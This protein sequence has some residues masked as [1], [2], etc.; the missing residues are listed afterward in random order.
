M[1][2]PLVKTADQANDRERLDYP[3]LAAGVRSQVRIYSSLEELPTSVLNLFE[4]AGCQSIF[5]TLPWF[6]NF[7]KTA[8]APEDRVRIYSFAGP[9][10][11][12]T[13]AGILL[14][15]SSDNS[16]SFFSS[17]RLQALA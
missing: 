11:R 2:L 5:L 16:K 15:R 9:D 10:G 6:Q 7:I 14:M 17:R 8:L 13:S 3:P 4:E 1:S 12:G